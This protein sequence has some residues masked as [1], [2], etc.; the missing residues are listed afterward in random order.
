MPPVVDLHAH[1]TASDGKR[2]PTGLVELAAERG[3]D[4]LA[5]TDHDT[6]RGV[7]EAQ[8]AGR[9]LGVAVLPGIEISGRWS[10]G[11]C[12]LL[13][14]LPD[15]VP[16]AF[17]EWTYAKERDR[18]ERAREMVERL[19]AGGSGIT[20]DDVRARAAVNIG[21]PHVADALVARGEADDRRHAFATL[22]GTGCAAY[23]PSGR[24]APEEAIALAADAGALVSLA[25]PYSLNLEEADLE[26]AVAGFREAGLGAIEAHRGDQEPAAQ[27][28]YRDLARRLDL[29]V[30][31]GSDYHEDEREATRRLGWG[32]E[33]GIAEDD[34]DALLSRLPGGP[35]APAG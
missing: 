14:Y 11:Q 24:V 9:R 27:A 35:G 22:I 31:V 6:L 26:R 7:E 23:V 10:D 15:P 18:E 29:L 4:V 30:T 13:A 2:T 3:V 34:L 16:P 19:Q 33:P 12:H 32:G 25:H 20:W 17:V 8:A 28:A 1:S 5:L 21:R